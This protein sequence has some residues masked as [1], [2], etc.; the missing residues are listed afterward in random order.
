MNCSKPLTILNPSKFPDKPS[1]LVRGL[2][3]PIRYD[4][5]VVPCGQCMACIEKR[6]KDFAFRIRS[7]AEKRGTFCFVT[8]TYDD[9]HLPLVSTLWRIDK[10]TG[11]MERLTEPDFV[12][13]SGREDFYNERERM[14]EV[15]PTGE[16]RY[17]DNDL[18][19]DRRYRYIARITPSVCRKDVQNWLKRCRV[20]FERKE[21][22]KLDFSYSIC[23]EYGSRFCRPHYHLALLGLTEDDA[24]KM[25]DLWK[26]GF[27]KLDFVNRVNSDGSDGFGKVA[28]YIAKYVS[29]GDFRCDSEKDCTAF[30]C[31]QMNSKGLGDDIVDKFRNYALAFDV[32]GAPYDPDTFFC[33]SAKRYL[34]RDEIATLVSEIPKRLAVTYDGKYYYA[35]PRLLRQKIFYVKTT[36]EALLSQN[37]VT[38]MRPSK[39]WRMVAD[40]IR[41]QYAELDRREFAQFC[42]DKSPREI[43]KACATFNLQSE[44]FAQ[45]SDSIRKEN[46]KARLQSSVF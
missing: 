2:P 40:A 15:K 18:F 31:R 25:C 17:I 11:E 6:Q 32:V 19:Q 33:Q 46:Y 22:R 20:Y 30:P 9:A 13:Y 37:K 34:R 10:L 21:G 14:S 5:I 39:L 38:Y 29:K 42:A 27:Y 26:L 1:Q 7:E 35:I 8:L 45:Y 12:C 36:R 43:A 24:R 16:P 4:S 44:V 28:N 23:S 3:L 41:S